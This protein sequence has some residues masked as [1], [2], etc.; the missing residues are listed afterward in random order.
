[1]SYTYAFTDPNT[2]VVSLT[3]GSTGF[4]GILCIVPSYSTA[5][6]DLYLNIGDTLSLEILPDSTGWTPVGPFWRKVN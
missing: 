5:R 1:M 3:P 6:V 2:Q 4:N